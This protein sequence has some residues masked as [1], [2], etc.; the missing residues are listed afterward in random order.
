MFK[1]LEVSILKAILGGIKSY[2]PQINDYRGTGGTDN[3]DY[4]YCVWYRH[5]IYLNK[6]GFTEKDFQ[7][8]IELGP[9]E[10]LAVSMAAF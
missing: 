4:C 6:L 9:G 10:S 3:F 7:N 2:L 8:M 1:F 5:M